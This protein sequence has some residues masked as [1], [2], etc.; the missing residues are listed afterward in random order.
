MTD[1]AGRGRARVISLF[2]PATGAAVRDALI[3]V[4]AALTA[5]RID[6]NLRDRA[7]IALAEA[8]N[9]IVEHAY[10]AGDSGREPMITL[11]VAADRGGLQVILRDR[12]GPMPDGRLPGAD[13]PDIDADDPLALPEG[14]W[15]WPLL[16]RTARS[17]SLSRR[18]DQNIL[19]F[20]L[21]LVETPRET[22]RNAM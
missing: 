22:G 19:R 14:G 21:P 20:R 13:L 8:C 16:R 2:F 12:G 11:D 18:N 10:A 7:Q 9:N 17:L 4:D 6:E 15:G 1:R 5:A 3:A